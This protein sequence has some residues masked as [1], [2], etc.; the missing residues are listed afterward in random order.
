MFYLTQC[1]ECSSV[2]SLS[3]TTTQGKAPLHVST[4]VHFKLS[5]TTVLECLCVHILSTGV[6]WNSSSTMCW[7][8]F[9]LHTASFH[10]RALTGFLPPHKLGACLFDVLAAPSPQL[11]YWNLPIVTITTHHY[12]I[13]RPCI[14]LTGCPACPSYISPHANWAT[15]LVEPSKFQAGPTQPSLGSPW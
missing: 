3:I 13:N 10:T 2:W 12:L 11:S 7:D 1:S 15:P 9:W 8:D 6:R 4:V 14:C 5:I